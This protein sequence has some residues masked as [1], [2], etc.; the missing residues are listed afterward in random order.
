MLGHKHAGTQGAGYWSV[1]KCTHGSVQATDYSSVC[2][3]PTWI[4]STATCGPPPAVGA[5]TKHTAHTSTHPSLPLP[6][7]TTP[8][9]PHQPSVPPPLTM[10]LL[11]RQLVSPSTATWPLPLAVTPKAAQSPGVGELLPLASLMWLTCR[12]PPAGN[13]AMLAP[14]EICT[15]QRSAMQACIE[16]NDIGP[17]AI[18]TGYRLPL[19]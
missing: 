14:Y 3:V 7:L 15:Q 12:M 4:P 2:K 18:S 8:P 9:H 13:L 10:W 6:T 5:T 1:L 11:S 19:L 16:N 17:R